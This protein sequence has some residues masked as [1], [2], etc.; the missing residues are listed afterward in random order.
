[1]A[2]ADLTPKDAASA[3]AREGR[4]LWSESLHRLLKNK[5]AVAGL[6]FLFVLLL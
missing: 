5:A 4:S 3:P 1:M 2:V 6:I